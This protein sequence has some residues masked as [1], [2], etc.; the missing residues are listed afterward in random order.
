MVDGTTAD[1]V[2]VGQ[3]T[4]AVVFRN[5]DNQVELVSGYHFHYVVFG[6]RTFIGPEYGCSRY[7]VRVEERGCTGGSVDVIAVLAQ[8]LAGIQ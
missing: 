6:M 3:L 8:F 4:F 5:V 2:T 1:T 7:A